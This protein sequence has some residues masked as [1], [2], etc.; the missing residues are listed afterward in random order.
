MAEFKDRQK[1]K[2]RKKAMQVMQVVMMIKT[3]RQ[4]KSS[5]R[6]YND[7]GKKGRNLHKCRMNGALV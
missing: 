2:E 5:M 6:R 4:G 3:T 7:T 1:L